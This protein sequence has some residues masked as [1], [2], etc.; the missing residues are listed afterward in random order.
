MAGIGPFDEGINSYW[1]QE[2]IRT[3]G[4]ASGEILQNEEESKELNEQLPSNRIICS[5]K[6]LDNFF[7]SLY[8]PNQK[9]IYNI[10]INL[11]NKNRYS[12]SC[13]SL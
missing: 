8:N 6:Q 7:L 13:I 4:G 2:F 9:V 5:I 12:Y 3:A 11:S 1:T 10:Y